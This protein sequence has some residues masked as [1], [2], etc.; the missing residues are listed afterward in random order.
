MLCPGTDLNMPLVT[1][2]RD[3]HHIK[4]AASLTAKENDN[5]F[6]KSKFIKSN[7]FVLKKTN[8]D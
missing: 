7:I 6:I 1:E 8:L 5:I 4:D 3:E 2:L